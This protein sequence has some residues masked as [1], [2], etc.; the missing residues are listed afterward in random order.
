MRRTPNETPYSGDGRS[1]PCLVTNM[2]LLVFLLLF[3]VA[4]ANAPV[5]VTPEGGNYCVDVCPTYAQQFDTSVRTNEVAPPTLVYPD[6]PVLGGV[7]A[8]AVM[9]RPLRGPSPPFVQYALFLSV[10]FVECH[11][12]ILWNSEW[13]HDITV[14]SFWVSEGPQE[15]RYFSKGYRHSLRYYIGVLTHVSRINFH[16]MKKIR[17]KRWPECRCYYNRSTISPRNSENGC[18]C[19]LMCYDA[20]HIC[21][22]L[23]RYYNCSL[24]VYF[25]GLSSR[26]VWVDYVAD[27]GT[28][29]RAC[30][31]PPQCSK[32]T[33][34]TWTMITGGGRPPQPGSPKPQLPAHKAKY[35]QVLLCSICQAIT[36]TC[37]FD[38]VW[39]ITV[40]K[41]SKN[42]SHGLI[43]IGVNHKLIF[44]AKQAAYFVREQ[45]GC[46][47][48]NCRHCCMEGAF[49]GCIRSKRVRMVEATLWFRWCYYVSASY[50]PLSDY[51]DGI[52][53]CVSSHVLIKC[54]YFIEEYKRENRMMLVELKN[55]TDKNARYP[56][57]S[58]CSYVRWA[59]LRLS[60]FRT[61]TSN[62]RRNTFATYRN[63]D[64]VPV[65]VDNVC[66]ATCCESESALLS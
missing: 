41:A 28:A 58:R 14:Y 54:L 56:A 45:A 6:G 4:N 11:K 9:P 18:N 25:Q 26:A 16:L 17:A 7:D 19:A 34:A 66:G 53:M 30:V 62:L 15:C 64:R 44:C 27:S 36:G 12:Y 33:S 63:P 48:I 10:L 42:H 61:P 23:L 13:N 49:H 1:F 52:A 57:T 32:G 2:L 65:H 22:I 20:Y 24:I 3:Q 43:N 55:T 38:C 37:H 35:S 50:V 5:C 47:T 46:Q 40:Y 59:L 31:V 39:D 51:L 8:T 29:V 60:Q 21:C